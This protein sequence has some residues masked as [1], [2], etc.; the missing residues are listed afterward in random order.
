VYRYHR[1]DRVT[2]AAYAPLAEPGMRPLLDKLSAD[3]RLVAVGAAFWGEPAGLALAQYDSA[4]RQAQL[5]DFFVAP[6]CRRAGIGTALL[7]QL[8]TA[9]G[10]RACERLHLIYK[11]DEHTPALERVLQKRGWEPPHTDARLFWLDNSISEAPWLRYP[12]P[13]QY[14]F[15]PWLELTEAERLELEGRLQDPAWCPPGLSPFILS[16][17]ALHPETSVGL[18]HQ[19]KVVGWVITRLLEPGL[20]LY[21]IFFVSPELQRIGRGIMLLGESI[22]RC[23]QYA[24]QHNSA[25]WHGQGVWRVSPT[26]IFMLKF[27]ERRMRPYVTHRAEERQCQKQ[28]PPSPPEV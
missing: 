23:C 5:L 4:S 22:R 3:A 13:P 1:L 25:L 21:D 12:L 9:L 18:R 10:E 6:H 14:A 16:E 26:N 15:F 2:A 8:E 7:E 20:V 24:Q 19:G 17:G 11:T 28:L 27:V